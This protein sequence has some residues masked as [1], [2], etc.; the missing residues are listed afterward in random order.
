MKDLIIGTAGHI[1]H[2]KTTLVHALTGIDTDRLKEEKA[3]GITIDIGF[4]HMDLDGYRLGFIDV[5]G[6]ER[7]VKNMLAGIGGIHLVML[8]V[9]ADESV[10][11]QTR[12]HFE[13]CRLLHI[14]AGIVVISKKNLVDDELVLLVEEEVRELMAGSFLENAPLVRVDSLSGEGIPELR[15]ALLAQLRKLDEKGSFE[16]DS[17]RLFRLPVDRVFS[18]RGFGTVVTG[19]PSGGEVTKDATIAV[20]PFGRTAK[21]R[22][23][24]IFNQKAEKVRSGQRTALNLSGLNKEDLAR[25][26]TLSVPQ[27]PQPTLML[28]AS[29]HLLPRA[30]SAL[31]HRSP[32]RFHQGSAELMGRLYLLEGPELKQG[33]TALAQIRLDS[34]ALCF[35]GD[36][37]VLRR[38][39]PLVTIGGGYVLDNAPPKYRRKDLLWAVEELSK[40]AGDLLSAQAD[41]DQALLQYVIQRAGLKGLNF[42][43]LAARTGMQVEHLHGKLHGLPSVLVIS[44]ETPLAVSRAHLDQLK[45]RIES[46]LNEFHKRNPLSAGV[47]REE[48]KRRFLP[49]SGSGYFLHVLSML[50]EEGIACTSASVVSRAGREVRLT[51]DQEQMQQEILRQFHQSGLLIT[52]FDELS[53]RLKKS[54]DQLRDLFFFL[55]EKGT[56]IRLSGDLVTH[57]DH[58]QAV[59]TKLRNSLPKEAEF[60]VPEFKDLFGLSRKYAIP[61]LEN[62]D[63]R[64]VTRR[65]GDLRRLL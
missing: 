53:A 1:D 10:M 63:R 35:P 11:P 26:M 57:P 50:Q 19:T 36:R 22:G 32:V 9:A 3:R 44:Q 30:P 47:S 55:L 42:D 23:I 45:S 6:H 46:Y 65:R 29:V 60:S 41:R 58:L 64:K 52:T 27:V 37:F 7:F 38:Y 18:V 43:E 4:A 25:G 20:Y 31:K 34:P 59:I 5:P 39:S 21:V 51:P 48:L 8:V 56:L 33:E 17:S 40:L 62:L 54:P 24:E 49:E 12:E 28:D 61:L 2:G 13:I 15:N 16:F 14:P